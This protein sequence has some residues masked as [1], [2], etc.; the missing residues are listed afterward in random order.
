VRPFKSIQIVKAPVDAM[1][2][3]IRD[4]LDEL[5]V[6]LDDIQSVT[7]E[8]R[9]ELPDGRLSLINTWQAKARLPAVLSSIIKPEALAWTDRATWDTAKH[10][11]AWQIELHF[12]RERTQCHGLTAFESA[13]GGR[14]TR[15]TF[16]GEF[17]MNAHSLPGVPALFE[18]TVVFAAE[19]FVTSLIPT[20]FRKLSIAAEKLVNSG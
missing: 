18:S 10:E 11:S 16:S 19:S 7:V 6:Q 17:A 1:W 12:A 5:V 3:A 4:R 15:V 8:H 14:G 9:A 20:N 13:I 2:A